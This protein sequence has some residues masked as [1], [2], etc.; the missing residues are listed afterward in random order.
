MTPRLTA[1][2]TLVDSGDRFVTIDAGYVGHV[3]LHFNERIPAEISELNGQQS[4]IRIIVEP[5]AAPAATLRPAEEIARE[6][7]REPWE[8]ALKFWEF[9]FYPVDGNDD[10]AMV[11]EDYSTEAA[12]ELDA[13]TMR[14]IV[15]RLI[16]QARADG[17]AAERERVVARLRRMAEESANDRN[18]S[19]WTVAVNVIE[20]ESSP[21]AIVRE[22]EP[23][24]LD[25]AGRIRAL[26]MT[27]AARWADANDPVERDAIE[28]VVERLQYATWRAR[29]G[30]SVA[31]VADGMRKDGGYQVVH[32]AADELETIVRKHEEASRCSG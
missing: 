14:T 3:D 8:N 17:A 27:W 28:Y 6:M 19:A 13:D 31:D 7:V 21:P 10:G 22:C 1:L 12:A 2:A 23:Q 24:H 30:R 32:Q 25:L 29:H 9:W 15:V 26:F 11:F 18:A 5:S 4:A 20:R 16:E